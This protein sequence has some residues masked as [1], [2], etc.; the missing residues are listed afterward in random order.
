MTLSPPLPVVK[1]AVLGVL[2]SS[3]KP[4]PVIGTTSDDVANIGACRSHSK[5]TT[6]INCVSGS[7]EPNI[8]L[9]V[10]ATIGM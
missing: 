7:N 9:H 8:V 5:S 1:G 4:L 10:E 2:I 6:E 3:N